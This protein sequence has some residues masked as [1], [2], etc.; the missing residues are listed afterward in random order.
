[1]KKDVTPDDPRWALAILSVT[2]A[3]W[4]PAQS[5]RQHL[6]A[7]TPPEPWQRRAAM[8][9]GHPILSLNPRSH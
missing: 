9:P 2:A 3:S 7:L 8:P 1:M 6:R 5:Y 4:W